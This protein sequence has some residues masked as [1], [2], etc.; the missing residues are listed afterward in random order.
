M[1]PR[2]LV[3]DDEPDL[4]ILLSQKFRR[5]IKAGEL[6]FVFA[7]DGQEALSILQGASDIG[8][9]LSDIN[10]PRMDGLTLLKRLRDMQGDRKTVIVSA[11]GDMKNIRTA[12][13]LGAFDF[14]TKPIEFIDLELTINKTIEDLDKIRDAHQRRQA[15]ERARANLSRYFSPKLAERLAEDPEGAGLGGMRR[16]LTIMFTDLADFT[17][18]VESLEP[19]VIAPLMNAYFEGL[20][21]TVFEHGGTVCKIVGDAMHAIFGAPEDQ[22]DHAE[23]GVACA[24]AIDA[25]AERFRRGRVAEGVAFGATRIGV[26][27]G[28]AIVGNFGGTTYFDYSAYGTSTNIASR[29]QSANKQLGTRICV[30]EVVA[31]SMGGFTGRRVGR[32]TLKG[33]TAGLLAFEPLRRDE[34]D[35]PAVLAYRAAFE[36]LE[37]GDAAGAKQ[38]FASMVGL[39]EDDPLAAFHLRRLLTGE[40]GVDIVISDK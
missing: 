33:L 38:A 36:K 40:S 3:V 31:T 2:I 32:L 9:V 16:D 7:R 26:H 17:P 35:G 22:S 8:I 27:T 10:M 15:A 13:N 34:A 25:F 37:K 5:Q 21:R 12:M 19:S 4:E 1:V 14:V 30:S 23:R 11:Y 24:L 20:T 28:P 29:L 39:Y 6:D 18:L